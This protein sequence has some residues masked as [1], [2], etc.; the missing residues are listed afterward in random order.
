MRWFERDSGCVELF[1]DDGDDGV[2]G[3][4]LGVLRL[5]FGVAVAA[6]VDIDVAADVDVDVVELEFDDTQT[7][8]APKLGNSPLDAASY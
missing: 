1:G 2:A 3:A 8:V 6:D 7:V 5:D 4:G